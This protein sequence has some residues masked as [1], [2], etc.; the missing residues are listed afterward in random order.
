MG[1]YRAVWYT[2]VKRLKST[3]V[4]PW[5]KLYVEAETENESFW[6]MTNAIRRRSLWRL[7]IFMS[8]VIQ[9]LNTYLETIIQCT[10]GFGKS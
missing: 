10:A 5:N 1:A 3:V 4:T 9:C 8:S 7:C 6:T 2:V